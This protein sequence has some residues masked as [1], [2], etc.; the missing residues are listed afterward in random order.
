MDECELLEALLEEPVE[1]RPLRVTGP[2][3]PASFPNDRNQPGEWE[4]QRDHG[5]ESSRA[6]MGGGLVESSRLF[7][8]LLSP[9]Q[10]AASPAPWNTLSAINGFSP[11]SGRKCRTRTGPAPRSRGSR[12]VRT[13]TASKP[14]IRQGLNSEQAS[15]R[16]EAVKVAR[17]RPFARTVS[18][19]SHE[20]H[21]SDSGWPMRDSPWTQPDSMRDSHGTGTAFPPER[22]G[23]QFQCQSGDLPTA[24]RGISLLELGLLEEAGLLKSNNRTEEWAPTELL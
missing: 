14:A 24:A 12:T 13:S 21:P 8:F 11:E 20:F 6:E 2:V 19:S 10:S 3:D 15:H 5:H 16:L 4:S 18:G 7:L 23:A 1:R 17:N 9:E 22:R